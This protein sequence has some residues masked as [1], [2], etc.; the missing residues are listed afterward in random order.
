MHP[1]C[2]LLYF[3]TLPTNQLPICRRV[4]SVVPLSIL[5]R[6]L[7]TVL[8]CLSPRRELEEN[9]ARIS[10][11]HELL[12][13]LTILETFRISI[14]TKVSEWKQLNSAWWVNSIM[15]WRRRIRLILKYSVFWSNTSPPPSNIDNHRSVFICA[16]I[17]VFLTPLMPLLISY[18]SEFISVPKKYHGVIHG[19]AFWDATS[20]NFFVSNSKQKKRS[21]WQ[22]GQFCFQD[23]C[24]SFSI[25]SDCKG[26]FPFKENIFN[27]ARCIVFKVNSKW[28]WK[29]WT[30]I[31]TGPFITN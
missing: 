21:R 9:G 4:L 3:L 29:Q 30:G 1:H 7:P 23:F 17:L 22:C 25:F 24:V 18:L 27:S 19:V 5:Q 6:N 31:V 14:L 28:L 26:C 16:N 8:L 12:R 2:A 11:F 15:F 20:G 10:A 13:S